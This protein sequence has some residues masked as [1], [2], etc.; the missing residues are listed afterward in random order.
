[1]LEY[2]FSRGL[3][4]HFPTD[5]PVFFH[6][7]CHFA[8][9]KSQALVKLEKFPAL[10]CETV[11]SLEEMEISETWGDLLSGSLRVC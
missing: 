7:S 1:L 4:H 2:Q 8:I 10:M 6:G 5:F 9:S 11:P 3:N